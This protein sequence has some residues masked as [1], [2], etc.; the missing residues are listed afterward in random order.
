M[1][2]ENRWQ[3]QNQT[4]RN[5]LRKYTKQGRIEFVNGGLGSNDEATSHYEDIITQ[6]DEGLEFLRKEIGVIPRVGYQIDPFGHSSGQALINYYLGFGYLFMVRLHYLEK[7]VRKL[8]NDL[9][10]LWKPLGEQRRENVLTVFYH[11][12]Y[13]SNSDSCW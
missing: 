6:Y 8:N 11:S 1:F 13:R 4:T 7:I 2:Q 12:H 10:F 9:V 3:E 5:T